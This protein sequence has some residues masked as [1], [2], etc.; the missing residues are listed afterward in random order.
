M[1]TLSPTPP[2]STP[3]S[4]NPLTLPKAIIDND[5]K[6]MSKPNAGQCDY[7][8]PYS[9]LKQLDDYYLF[10]LRLD[11]HESHDQK[12]AM[13]A[14]FASM[15]NDLTEFKASLV[16]SQMNETGCG[17]PSP[18]PPPSPP[19]PPAPPSSAC[20]FNEGTGL[21]GSDISEVGAQSKEACC[22]GCVANARCKAATFD[23]ESGKC[24]MKGAGATVVHGRPTDSYTCFPSPHA[25]VQM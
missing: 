20:T 1:R 5:W 24:H 12:E 2:F 17:R 23:G 22:G 4:D 3:S 15:M 9:Q 6:L 13:P 8:L 16:T 18:P 14:L 10:N 11:Y 25:P 19:V 7:Q 21:N